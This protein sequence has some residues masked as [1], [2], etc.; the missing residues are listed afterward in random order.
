MRI[1]RT[2]GAEAR[3]H[4][5]DLMARLKSCPSRTISP[6]IHLIAAEMPIERSCILGEA[7]RNFQ[8]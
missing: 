3:L 5:D 4:F 8:A 1:E 2:P 7:S 6:T